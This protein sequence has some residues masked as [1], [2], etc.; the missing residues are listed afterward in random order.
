MP[1]FEEGRAYCF[2]AVRLSVDEDSLD[3]LDYS[4]TVGL[5]KTVGD[6]KPSNAGIDPFNMED[7]PKDNE[8]HQLLPEYADVNELLNESISER[9]LINTSV[10]DKTPKQEFIRCR[11]REHLTE[12]WQ[13]G[14]VAFGTKQYENNKVFRW[15][16]KTLTRYDLV[17]SNDLIS[18]G[19]KWSAVTVG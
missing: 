12:L 4:K 5:P 16:R 15:K 14:Q 9:R 13:N 11:D 1:F 19:D 6:E 2:A 7:P 8:D 10:V 17:T 3:V 18:D